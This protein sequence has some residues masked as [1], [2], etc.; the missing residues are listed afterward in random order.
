MKVI[1]SLGWA[2]AGSLLLAG[3]TQDT[4]GNAGIED[5]SHGSTAPDAAA[6]PA[7]A[8]LQDVIET[9]PTHIIG[10]SYP[11][12]LAAPP[13]L[14]KV[15]Q[16]YADQARAGLAEALDAL[17]N[18]KPRVPYEL[19]LSFDVTADTEQLL[20]ISADGSRYT[21]GAHGEPLMARFVWLKAADTLLSADALIN[22]PAGRAAVAQYVEDTLIAQMQARLE[23]ERLDA[24]EL[25]SARAQAVEMIREGT[26]PQAE[27]F[28][29]LQPVVDRSGKITAVRFVFPPYQVGPYSDGTQS[30][31]VPA[32]VML[33]YVAPQY[34]ELFSKS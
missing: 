9:T 8:V 13:G 21:G 25:A 31:D 4:P 15:M 7:A 27:N 24:G 19:S 22:D 12:D 14:A 32:A 2:M 3:C 34:A 17:G 29:Q 23:A 33:R 28:R 6:A 18:D 1:S 20:A 11:K 30:V 26:E 10:I 5:G 16:A